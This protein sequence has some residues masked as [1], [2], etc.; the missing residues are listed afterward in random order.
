MSG[1]V[2]FLK[3][4]LQDNLAITVEAKY[5]LL[6]DF[7]GKAADDAGDSLEVQH[8]ETATVARDGSNVI[9][10]SLKSGETPPDRAWLKLELGNTREVA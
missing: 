9:D 1:F 10:I 5:Q 3:A 8:T 4:T 6:E 2:L 7:T